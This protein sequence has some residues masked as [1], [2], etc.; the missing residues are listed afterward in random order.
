M[1]N[2]FHIEFGSLDDLANRAKKAMTAGVK[3]TSQSAMFGNLNEFMEFM[4]PTKFHLLM[5]IKVRQPKSIYELAQLI[6]K[7]QPGI[8]KEC[9]ELELMNFITLE[10]NGARNALVPKLRFN[11]NRLIVHSVEG[12]F[13]HTLPSAA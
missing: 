1:D 11:Y 10:Q 13:N 8:L 7:S 4:F 5:L 6:G 3:Q 2:A 9:R 12:E